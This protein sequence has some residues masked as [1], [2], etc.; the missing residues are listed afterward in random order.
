MQILEFCKGKESVSVRDI[1]R[2]SVGSNLSSD[3]IKYA[4]EWL[5]N[6]GHGTVKTEQI[7]GSIRV[8]FI[9]N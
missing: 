5:E 3:A 7:G 9:P 2:S 1:Q 4:F 6:N 8:S